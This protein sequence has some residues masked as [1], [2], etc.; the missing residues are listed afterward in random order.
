MTYRIF[1]VGQFIFYHTV[2]HGKIYAARITARVEN[3]AII[4]WFEGNIYAK[5]QRPKERTKRVPIHRCAA[6]MAAQGEGYPGEQVRC[7]GTLNMRCQD[8]Q[9]PD[10]QFGKIL[11]PIRFCDEALDSH[12][13]ANLSLQGQLEGAFHAILEILTGRREHLLMQRFEMCVLGEGLASQNR[14]VRW[15]GLYKISIL[16]GDESLFGPLL[17]DLTQRLERIP[18]S[19]RIYGPRGSTGDL[20]SGPG[21]LL[22]RLVILREYLGRQPCDDD[23]IYRLVDR[24]VDWKAF[25]KIS[26]AGTSSRVS[27]DVP[28]DDDSGAFLG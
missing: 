19:G 11:W 24:T 7:H 18:P 6:A 5:S 15:Y 12:G 2:S 25:A 21:K 8:S 16:D 14:I 28:M 3:H 20:V 4:E 13:Y 22:F 10:V 9:R 17:L 23:E 26:K 1:R 27:K